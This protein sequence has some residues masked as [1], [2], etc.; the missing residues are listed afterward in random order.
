MA[1]ASGDPQQL[2]APRRDLPGFVTAYAQSAAEE[3]RAE[4]F[5]TLIERR[6]LAL[7]LIANDPVIAAKCRFV[8]DAIGRIHPGMREALGY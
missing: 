2:R 1:Q 8:L 3:D 4:V 6:P 5:A 7:E